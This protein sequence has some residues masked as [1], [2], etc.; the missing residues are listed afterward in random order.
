MR[1]QNKK[2]LLTTVIATV[3]GGV[4]FNLDVPGNA[5]MAAGR[6]DLAMPCYQTMTSFAN[7][8]HIS[9]ERTADALAHLAQC[10][11]DADKIDEAIKVDQQAI[12]MYKETNGA[13]STP[14]FLGMARLGEYMNNKGNYER[15]EMILT[16]AV[17]G[18][19]RAQVPDTE[20]LARVYAVLGDTLAA[21]G[22]DYQAIAVFEKL[23]PIDE[24]LMMQ[25]QHS[26]D[27]YDRL[28]AVYARLGKSNLSKQTIEA[29]IAIKE[30]ILGAHNVQVA[31]SYKRLA[32][33]QTAQR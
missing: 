8:L 2:L 23:L 22:K 33:V 30:R 14:V 27:S 28:A 6:S 21:Q 15:A 19:E 20:A 31:S 16:D 11:A 25:K 7:D 9:N 32:E 18:L 5:L 26:V 24:R 10:Y 29:G 13:D 1:T 12:N 3:L 17:Q 4:G